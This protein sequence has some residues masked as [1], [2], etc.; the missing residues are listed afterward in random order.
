MSG[1]ARAGDH[2]GAHELA[3]LDRGEADATRRA[4]HEEGLSGL[5]AGPVIQGQVAGSIRNLEGGSI[6]EAHAVGD[7][8]GA[9]SVKDADL[10][11]P[12]LAAEHRDPVA[13][14]KASHA[15]AHR[16]DRAGTSIPRVKGSGGVSWYFPSTISRSAKLSPQALIFTLICPDAHSGMA[17]SVRVGCFS[18][19]LRTKDSIR[20]SWIVVV[21]VTVLLLI[22][23]IS[24]RAHMCLSGA[25][26]YNR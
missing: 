15:V 16:V 24:I 9:G 4:K 13:R 8:H 7:F 21:K 17:I 10:R 5:Q 26:I 19:E 14:R 3:D 1:T 20:A 2:G 25:C 12:A 18:C 11:K 23:Q 6:L 22:C